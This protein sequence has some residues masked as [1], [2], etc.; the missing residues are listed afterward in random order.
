M[1]ALVNDW[2][3]SW[4]VKKG[5]ERKEERRE[6]PLTV[7][8]REE[9]SHSFLEKAGK[10]EVELN[11]DPAT[12]GPTRKCSSLCTA[13]SQ[14]LR[15]LDAVHLEFSTGIWLRPAHRTGGCVN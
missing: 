11:R 1:G 15:C 7:Q 10:G 12:L 8:Q 13:A 6:Y 14:R 2:P 4:G 9:Q 5:K 3:S